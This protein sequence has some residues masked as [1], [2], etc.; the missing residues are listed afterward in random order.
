[1]VN[2]SNTGICVE[3]LRK[4]QHNLGLPTFLLP[5]STKFRLIL[6]LTISVHDY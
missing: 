3:F 2:A 4:N 1:M 5:A 6:I